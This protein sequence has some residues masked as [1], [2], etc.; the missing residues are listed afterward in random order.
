MDC[1]ISS[2][3]RQ[4]THPPK[5]LIL[6]HWIFRFFKKLPLT[7]HWNVSRSN[8]LW[9]TSNCMPI[10]PC[11]V[12]EGVFPSCS[13]QSRVSTSSN[14]SYETLEIQQIRCS[15]SVGGSPAI[16]RVSTSKV[17][18]CRDRNAIMVCVGSSPIAEITW[19]EDMWKHAPMAKRLRRTSTNRETR[20]QFPVE[21]KRV[22]STIPSTR[23][24]FQ[25]CPPERSFLASCRAD[26]HDRELALS[27]NVTI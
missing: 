4:D 2:D 19:S 1:T 27:N 9:Q 20:V 13:N 7:F 23:N 26:N 25:L 24:P 14:Q 22:D 21:V 17:R 8:T 11:H 6:F 12:R 16:L 15:F 5:K 10:P 18:I 3:H